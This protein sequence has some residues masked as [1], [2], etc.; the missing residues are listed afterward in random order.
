[1]ISKYGDKVG[2]IRPKLVYK[3]VVEVLRL[4]A[5]SAD[6]QLS[7]FPDETCRPDEVALTYDEVVSSAQILVDNNIIT[8]GTYSM[9]LELN[10]MYS[11][12]EVN[13]WTEN[14]MYTSRNW[15]KTR[16]V[17]AKILQNMEVAWQPPNLFWLTYV[18]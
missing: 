13:D 17:A 3:K 15:A 14:A 16:A 10:E 18:V 5:A 12:Y 1:M 9:I 7:Q 6:I 11:K 4:A 2:N 8:S